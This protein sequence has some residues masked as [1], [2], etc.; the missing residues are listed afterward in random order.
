MKKLIFIALFLSVF[1]GVF[2]AQ[3]GLESVMDIRKRARTMEKYGQQCAGGFSKKFG[4]Y[5]ISVFSLEKDP[6]LK[7][8]EI[9]ELA[10]LT[11][12]KNIAEFIGQEVSASQEVVSTPE[13]EK[14]KSYIKTNINNFLRGVVLY[15][16]KETA[17]DYRVVC[18]ATGR[19]M[20]M[21]A[22][23]QKQIAEL[24]EGTVA[25]TGIAYIEEKRLDLAKQQALQSAL[26]LAVE[27]VLGTEVAAIAQAQDDSRIRTRIYS[28]A[29]GFVEKYRI[30]NESVAD[31]CYKTLVYAKVSKERLL[32][33]YAA[34]M[35]SFGNPEF[36]LK[37]ENLELYQ[38]FVK[39]FNDLGLK[40][41]SDSQNADYIIDAFGQYRQLQHPLTRRQ[42]TQLSLWIRISDAATGQELLS[43]KND[44]RMAS[45]FVGIAERQLETATRKAFAQIKE[46]LHK[47]LNEMITEMAVNGREVTITVK[48]YTSDLAGS[49]E[50][51]SNSLENMP[52]LTVQNKKI[53]GDCVVYSALYRGRMDDLE[54]FLRNTLRNGVTDKTKKIPQTLELSTNQLI[55]TF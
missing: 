49:L 1:T 33:S 40:M 50:P 35:K 54:Y 38:T 8:R 11:G 22:E 14:Y 44:P 7:S 23:L 52:G 2:Q 51:L 20:D 43:Q 37:T 28:N 15:D 27:Q 45:A 30:I 55:L 13:Y 26:R 10:L 24:P 25:A 3:E 42:G 48:K 18:F 47:A 34:Y 19:T 6:A 21:A 36:Y 46:P 29:F 17:K 53:F 32:R 39:F 16:I 4:V 12:K 5:I 41:T 31:D 9:F